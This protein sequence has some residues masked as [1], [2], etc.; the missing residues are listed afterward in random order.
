MRN[1][2]EHT[3]PPR[4]YS[5]LRF[6]TP[7][8][9]NGDSQRRQLDAARSYA[10]EHGLELDETLTFHDLGVSGFKGANA[11]T[12]AL[13]AFRRAVEEGRVEPGSYLLVEDFDR[14]SRMDPWEALP[15]FQEIINAGITIVTLKDRET[16]N[17]DLLRTDQFLLVKAMFS[18]WNGHNESV[19]K[20]GRV[21]AAY[22]A[23]RK[24]LVAGE[25][26]A[27]PYKRT[28]PA[29]VR[30]DDERRAF[31]LIP[32]RGAVVQRIFER[33]DAGAGINAIARELNTDNIP[34]WGSGKRKSAFWRGGYVRRILASKALI[35]TLTPHTTGSDDETG[36]RRDTALEPVANYY[37]IAVN[38]ELFERVYSRI[39]TTAARGR[40]ANRA[41]ASVVA[42]VAKCALCGGS[43]IRVTKGGNAKGTLQV[44]CVCQSAR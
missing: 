34:T 7:E 42:G 23:K 35:G 38:P 24:R 30:Y 44:H 31:V 5:Y 6:S 9:L 3:K 20:S 12:G 15:I 16:W 26:M 18:M 2:A 25:V 33:A 43:M 27:E 40:H 37:P 4:A 32:E 11:T 1:T 29:W 41:P 39:N 19:K 13:R 21:A 28:G 17:R 22:A 14:L 10:R 8:Q 36:A